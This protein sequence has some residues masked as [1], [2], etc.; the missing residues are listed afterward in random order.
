MIYFDHNAT[1]PIIPEVRDVMTKAMG[2]Y[3]GNPSSSH[4][5]GRKANDDLEF[6][7]S[8]LAELLGVL[9]D[10]IHFTSGGTD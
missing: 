10:E 7:R 9:P 8:K 1:T 3:W 2:R 4:T 5:I 6:A